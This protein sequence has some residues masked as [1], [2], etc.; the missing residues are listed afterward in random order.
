M[1]SRLARA[2]GKFAN[3]VALDRDVMACETSNTW[4]ATFVS[5]GSGSVIKHGANG[6]PFDCPL[7][8]PFERVTW[9][10]GDRAV[11]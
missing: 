2:A 11:R 9:G 5:G 6:A 8:N 4:S 1:L 10:L 7:Q 3:W